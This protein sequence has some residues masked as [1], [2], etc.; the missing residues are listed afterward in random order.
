MLDIDIAGAKSLKA[1]Q[2]RLNS[3]F[4]W[5]DAPSLREVERRLRGRN[6]ETEE[7]IQR[8][9]QTMRS[10]LAQV[11]EHPHLYDQRIIN[12]ELEQC[13]R[14]IKQFLRDNLAMTQRLQELRQLGKSFN[15]NSA[16][17]NHL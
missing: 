2:D 12:D 1:F 11:E 10:E 15:S 13:F 7:Q 3:Q 4:L 16:P 5:I 6:T 17:I 8:R 14:K 9:L